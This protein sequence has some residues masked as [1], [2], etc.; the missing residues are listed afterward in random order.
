[1]GVKNKRRNKC[2]DTVCGQ[3]HTVLISR[4]TCILA[5]A[6]RHK[7]SEGMS[8][9]FQSKMRAHRYFPKMDFLNHF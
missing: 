4:N 8:K 5:T 3:F 1:M 7:R 9:V 6:N 2:T